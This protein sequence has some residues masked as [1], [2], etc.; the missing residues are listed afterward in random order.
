MLRD[1]NLTYFYADQDLNKRLTKKT[2][3]SILTPQVEC[4]VLIIQN[5]K[6]LL[7]MFAAGEWLKISLVE[8]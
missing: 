4:G 2:L 8:D 6:G 1:Y 5:N 7:E 3:K